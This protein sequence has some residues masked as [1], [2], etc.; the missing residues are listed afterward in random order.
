M[1]LPGKPG[2]PTLYPWFW[3]VVFVV[4]IG[5]IWVVQV[6]PCKPTASRST[7][8]QEV[9]KKGAPIRE[10]LSSVQPTCAPRN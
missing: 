7:R 8:G 5:S 3:F 10:P 9:N 2:Q 1:T 6:N 4:F